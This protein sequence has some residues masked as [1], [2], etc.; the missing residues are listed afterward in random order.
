MSKS[1]FYDEIKYAK[2]EREVEAVYNKGIELYFTKNTDI[3]I[4]HPH[5]CDGLIEKTLEQPNLFNKGSFLK[6]LIEYKYD[7]ELQN[8]VSR[9]KVLV[10]VLYYLKRFEENGERLPNVIMVGDINEVFVIHSN[11]LIDYLDENV[12]WSIAPSEAHLHN[13]DLVMKLA[14]DENINPFVF[15]VDSKFSFKYVADKITDLAQNVKRRVRVTEHNISTIFDYFVSKVIK[16]SNKIEPIDLVDI[17]ISSIIDKENCYKHPNNPNILVSNG[18]H[19]QINGKIYDSFFSH[20]EKEYTPQEKNKFTE[21]SDRLIEDT[22][23]RINGEFYTPTLFADYAHKMLSE[24]LGEDWKEKYVVWDCC[25]GTGNLTRDYQFKELYASTLEQAELNCGQRYN[26]EA[27]KFVFDFLNDPI[28]NR[29]GWNEKIPTGLNNAFRENKP[30]IFFINPPYGTASNAGAKGTSKKGCAKTII[31]EKMLQHKI[32]NCSQNLYTQFLYRIHLI[33]E[34]YNLSNIVIGLYSPTLFLSGE[35]FKN[36]R[37]IFLNKFEYKKAIQFK[38]SYFSNVASQWGISFSIWKNGITFNKNEFTYSLIDLDENGNICSL[39]SKMVYNL[40]NIESASKWVNSKNKYRKDDV[41]VCFKSAINAGD[42]LKSIDNYALSYFINDQNNINA[43]M[44]GVYIINTPITRNIAT[45][46]IYEDNFFKCSALCT[47]RKVVFGDWI[48]SKDEYCFPN[49]NHPKFIKYLH[50][51]VIFSLFH[52]GAGQASCQT[53]LKNIECK[54]QFYNIKNEFFF[55]SK[56][57]IMDLANQ[58]NFDY[59]YNDAR[60]SDE[61]FVYKKLQE[62]ELTKEAQDVLNKAI[63]LTKKSFK[64]REMFNQEHPEYQIMNWDCGWYQIKA[65]LKEYFPDDLKEFQ[66][67]YKILADKMRPMVYELGFLK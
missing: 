41:M 17:F 35:S 25:W 36:F 62:I 29:Y 55:M 2:V 64:Y 19:I 10:Q 33:A 12:D 23:R 21:I 26:P 52:S 1:K 44:Q 24:E 34:H 8:D 16:D 60:V 48:N 27:K 63:E 13:I 45:V 51:S 61:R 9:A 59:T 42:K 37:K 57:K 50:D 18:K 54:G 43:N 58:Y 46:G 32:G 39:G 22:K 40:D 28:E 14:K 67:L 11:F 15:V 66:E 31:N 53:S 49:E 7:E 20:F 65:V 38:A 47:A 3:Q 6:L 56:N 5:A 30:I 4:Q